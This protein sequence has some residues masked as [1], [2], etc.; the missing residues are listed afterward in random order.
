MWLGVLVSLLALIPLASQLELDQKRS[1]IEQLD[2]SSIRYCELSSCGTL[3]IAGGLEITQELLLEE[4][5]FGV[6]ARLRVVN[7]GM[8]IGEREFWFELRSAEGER[9]ES[10]RGLLTLSPKGPQHI[11]FFFTG[12]A[13]EITE[14]ELIVGY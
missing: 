7:H 3:D 11:E 8:A 4:N 9:V 12:D 2:S 13:A 14:G 5:E 6:N 10:M 1:A